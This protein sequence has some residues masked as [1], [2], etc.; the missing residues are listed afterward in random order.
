MAITIT[1][2]PTSPNLANNTIVYAVTSNKD[3]EPQFKFVLDINDENGNLL[4]RLKQQPNVQ[5]TG[6]FNIGQIITN[7]LGPTDN[8]WKIANVTNNTA[9]GKDFLI[10]FGEEYATTATSSTFITTGVGSPSVGTP[11]A[12]LI[13]H[14]LE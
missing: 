2:N 14:L 8:V 5:G 12:S 6:I 13:Q 4:Q 7:Y 11:A 1:K 9:C 10:R 3:A